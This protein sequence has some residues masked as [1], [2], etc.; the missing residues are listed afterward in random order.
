MPLRTHVRL[1][2]ATLM[3]TAAAHAQSAGQAVPVTTATAGR[4]NVPVMADGIGTVQALQ[5]VAIRAQV[6]GTLEKVLFTEGQQVKKGDLLAVIDPRPYQA[7]LDQA[8]AKQAADQ[9]SLISAQA[10]LGRYD[11]LAQRSFASRQQVDQQRASVGQLTANLRGDAASIAAA[12]LNISFT[13]I[14]APFPGRVGLRQIDP[15]NLIQAN[16]SAIVTLAETHPI[17][18]IYTLPQDQVPAVRAA[19][20]HGTV[21][22]RALTGDG[23]T[24]LGTGTLLAI[25]AAIDQATGTIRLKATFPNPDER[26]WPGEFVTVRTQLGTL[27]NAVTIPDDAVQHGPDGLYVYEIGTNN[28]A[29]LQPIQL[30]QDQ[31]GVAVVAKGLTGGET[32]VISGQSRLAD[33]V[34]VTISN[35]GSNS[36][37]S[38]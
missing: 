11:A 30:A 34:R 6:G 4:R 25:D 13:Q 32:I 22:V 17:A 14:T 33:G 15:G 7:V 29:H 10:D 12:A 9:A 24:V 27:Q 21:P 5:S 2:A 31:D 3:L 38:S 37:Q 19:Q 16:A 23:K 35:S 8:R 26:L 1:I 18:V 28:K 20:S 36:G